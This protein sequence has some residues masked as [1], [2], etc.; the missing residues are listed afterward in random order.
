MNPDEV[1]NLIIRFILIMFGVKAISRGI[2]FKRKHSE[3]NSI[4]SGFNTF[5]VLG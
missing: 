2:K 3:G 5:T 1:I 4:F